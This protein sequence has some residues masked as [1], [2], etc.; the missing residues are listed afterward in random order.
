MVKGPGKIIKFWQEL[1]R[2]KVVRVIIIYASTAFILLQLVS[3]LADET[4]YGHFE[5]CLLRNQLGGAGIPRIF[6]RLKKE[7]NSE[8][9]MPLEHLG[10]TIRDTTHGGDESEVQKEVINWLDTYFG[11]AVNL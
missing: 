9:S 11:H 4:G 8:W 6:W 2:R 3:I 7:L 1:N 10:I 5:N